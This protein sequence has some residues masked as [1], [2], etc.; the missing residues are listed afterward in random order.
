M[1]HNLTLVDDRPRTRASRPAVLLMIVVAVTAL[2]LD[3]VTKLWAVAALGDGSRWELVPGL[4]W[5]QVTRNSGAAFSLAT[6]FTWVFTLVAVVV[7]IVICWL[8]R[9]LVNPWW[10]LT[11]GLV[12][13]GAVGNLM[14]RLLRDPGFA[15]G[16]VVDFIAVPHYPV[17]NVADSCIVVGAVLIGLLGLRGVT[18]DGSRND[19]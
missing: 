1:E 6:G 16:H 10:G 9:R 11:L 14:D 17:F 7:S 3:Q 8:A 18:L 4:L 19:G 5:F 12:L 2:L 15:R 13:G